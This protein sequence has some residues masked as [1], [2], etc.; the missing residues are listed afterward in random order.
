[1][2]SPSR[3]L[4]L[5]LVMSLLSLAFTYGFGRALTET[6]PRHHYPA[7]AETT[8]ENSRKM[9]LMIQV[10]DYGDPE[11]NTNPKYGNLFS[12]PAPSITPSPS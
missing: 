12:P 11:A 3:F 7:K 9:R 10:M 1:M 2:M 8:E 5:L 6:V 4:A